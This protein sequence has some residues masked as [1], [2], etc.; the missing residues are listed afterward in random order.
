[1]TNAPDKNVN[2]LTEKELTDEINRLLH[3]TW[4]Q[5]HESPTYNKDDW[6]RFQWCLE[7]MIKLL[8]EK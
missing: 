6:K 8:A 2:S 5:C 7:Q 3:L 1:M 4:G